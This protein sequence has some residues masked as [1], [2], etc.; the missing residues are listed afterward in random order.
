[1][2]D[3][4][5]DGSSWETVQKHTVVL[6]GPRDVVYY[7]EAFLKPLES[8]IGKVGENVLSFGPLGKPW[9]WWL[10]LKTESESVLSFGPLGK[11]WEWWL[12]LKTESESVWSFGPLGKP[13]EWWL[14]LKTESESV[15]SFGPLG[16]PWEWWLSLKTESESV[17]SFGPL[18]KP[19]EWW[20]TLKTESES[21]LSFGPLGRPWEWWLTLKTET[22]RDKILLAGALKV[23]H[24]F[25]V[26]SAAK[27]QFM[28][29]VHWAPPFV[30]NQHIA[31]ILSNHCQVI[32]WSK[33]YCV[34]D[35]FQ[36]CATDVR[37]IMC[38]GNKNV[39]PHTLNFVCPFTGETFE[40][41][42]TTIGHKPI[43]LR[44]RME[45]HI[46][47]DCT[48]AVCHHCAVFAIGLKIVRVLILAEPDV[49]RS[50]CMKRQI[51][52]ERCREKEELSRERTGTTFQSI[53]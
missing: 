17:L 6:T 12:T 43:C 3:C 15:L 10:T 16:K 53:L 25:R 32:I 35:G 51:Q 45:G 8:V 5:L 23:G 27:S 14:T 4:S 50:R 48:T 34:A 49:F 52:V 2:S 29:K 7:R 39:M 24:L 28:V 20:L 18:G 22:S 13:W 11:P 36:K 37:Q 46:R 21:V 19:W 42:L 31:D 47:R 1:M 30:S 40:I 33:E 26:R 44:C 38:E 9:E 41:L